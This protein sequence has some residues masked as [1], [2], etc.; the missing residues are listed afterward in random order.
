M[1]SPKGVG[2]RSIESFLD[3]ELRVSEIRD[4]SNNGVQVDNSGRITKVACGVDASLDFFEAAKAAKANLLIVHHGI[5]WKDSL[6]KITRLNY[7]RVKYLMDN[8]MALYA[9]HLPLDLHPK[10]GNN[11]LIAKMLGLKSVKPFGLYEGSCIGSIGNA[12]SGTKYAAFVKKAEKA[13]G[14]KLLEM[15]FGPDT[16]RKVAVVSGGGCGLLED[17]EEAGADMFVSGEP[18]LAGRNFACDAGMNALFG[19]HY[20]TEKYGAEALG[21]LVK[22]KFGL[23]FVFIDLEIDS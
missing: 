20:V 16:V 17:A 5:S 4:S 6:K 21:K 15:K 11:A 14:R 18:T 7:K 8:D 12:T 9:S 2:L 3:K 23:P 13:F 19:G 1:K 22:R 10:L